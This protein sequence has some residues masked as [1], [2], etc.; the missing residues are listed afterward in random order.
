MTISRFLTEI[1][2]A[3]RSNPRPYF[4]LD[5]ERRRAQNLKLAREIGFGLGMFQD[6]ETW[7]TTTYGR[8]IVA[9][10]FDSIGVVIDNKD[11]IAAIREGV[12]QYRESTH[13]TF[14]A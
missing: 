11:W 10:S 14:T 4:P 2:A 6:W 9:N 3:L 8:I 13:D 7:A 1:Q 5:K 12:E